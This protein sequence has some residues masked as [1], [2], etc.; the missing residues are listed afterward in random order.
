MP[1]KKG[2]IEY[3]HIKRLLPIVTAYNEAHPNPESEMLFS[4]VHLKDAASRR[5]PEKQLK[6]YISLGIMVKF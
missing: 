4:H 6:K 5:I 1:S 3:S 2:S